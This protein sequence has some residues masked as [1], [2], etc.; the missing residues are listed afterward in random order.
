VALE[1][2]I[3]IITTRKSAKYVDFTAAYIFQPIAMENL[4]PINASALDFIKNLGQKITYLSGDDKESQVLF[5]RISVTIQPFNSVLLR[6][7]FSIDCP[8]QQPCQLI[9]LTF[10]F[11]PREPLLPGY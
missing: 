9:F 1:I 8:D 10:I 5:Q 7:S 3:I 11:N 4:G 2:I 6:D